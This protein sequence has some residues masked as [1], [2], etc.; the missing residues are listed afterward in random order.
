MTIDHCLSFLVYKTAT[1]KVAAPFEEY[2]LRLI[3]EDRRPDQS[4]SSYIKD[5]YLYLGDHFRKNHEEYTDGRELVV[6]T[7]KESRSGEFVEK[8]IFKSED[9]LTVKHIM[10]MIIEHYIWW[11]HDGENGLSPD[12]E[13]SYLESLED[14]SLT[15]FEEEV[16]WI[17]KQIPGFSWKDF[18]NMRKLDSFKN[19]K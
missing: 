3:Y 17:E 4:H 11:S 16:N 10:F 6:S 1:K 7:G 8:F 18:Q 19:K 9:L 2:R 14:L 13:E 15:Q 12:E 5:N